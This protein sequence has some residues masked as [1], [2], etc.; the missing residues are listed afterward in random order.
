[1]KAK[2]SHSLKLVHEI[3]DGLHRIVAFNND[4]TNEASEW[5]GQTEIANLKGWFAITGESAL[6]QGIFTV[7]EKTH[8]VL[9]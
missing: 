9:S 6:P 3:R 8:Q 5:I 7:S 2:Q 4:G 1:M